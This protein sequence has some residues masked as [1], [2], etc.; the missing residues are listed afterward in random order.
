VHGP[1]TSIEAQRDAI[2]RP[3]PN[4]LHPANPATRISA[5]SDLHLDPN[6]RKWIST[7]LGWIPSKSSATKAVKGVSAASS[8]ADYTTVTDD[9]LSD[10]L[11]KDLSIAGKKILSSREQHE[12]THWVALEPW[13]LSDVPYAK[14]NKIMLQRCKKRYL[15]DYER[16]REILIDDPWL[17]DVWLWIEGLLNHASP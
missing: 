8:S 17:Q 6:M 5:A 1:M 4:A 7:T 14:M 13:T 9:A 15:F 11:L 2:F 10:L 3:A 16:N 12:Y